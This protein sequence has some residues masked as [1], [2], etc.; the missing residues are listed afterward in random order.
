[1][2][3]DWLNA[4]EATEVGTALA[5]DVVVQTQSA[6][7]NARQRHSERQVAPENQ[8][9]AL[10]SR[11]LQAVDRKARPLQLNV[12]KR[13]KL[14]NSFKWRLLEKGVERQVVEELT[15]ALVLRLTAS[16]DVH[17]TPTSRARPTGGSHARH[18]EALL[19]RA[20]DL[21]TNGAYQDAIG[22]FEEFLE[23]KPRHAV[24]RNNLGVALIRLGHYQEAEEQFRRA[25]GIKED[26]PD[27][28]CNIGTLLRSTGR[29][30]E[31][32]MPL[33]RALK[34]RPAYLEAQISL[35]F[36]LLMLGRLSEAR[37]V[38]ELALKAAPRN[39]DALIAM[40]EVL[41]HE[42]RFG[43][44]ENTYRTVLTADPKAGGAWMGLVGLRKM[45]AADGDWLR[46][47]EASIVPGMAP[48][49][50][51]SLH[52][53]IGKYYD[54]LGR[55][56]R[57]FRSYQRANELWKMAAKP[58]LPKAREHLT[59]DLIRVY[60]PETLRQEHAGASDSTLPVFVVGMPRAGTT[61]VEQIIASHPGARGAG[62][63]E[64]WAYAARKHEAMQRQNPPD[65][66]TARKL[67]RDYLQ[68]LEKHRGDAT[69]VVDKSPF[70]TDYLGAIHSVF[71]RARVIYV[72]RNPIDVCL[73]CYFQSFAPSLNFTLDLTDL[74]HY[75]QE[76]ARLIAHWR[77]ALPAGTWFEVP[78]EALV[79]D[80]ER[81]TRSILEFLGLQW[82]ERCL[83][84]HQ[85]DRT[86]GTASVW[87]VRQKMYRTSVA[88]WRNYE[89]FIGPLRKLQDLA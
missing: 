49:N 8:L 10:L 32:E 53:A 85:T 1:M 11:F 64:Y 58:Y 7:R 61:L 89:K 2:L 59:D 5:D 82:H 4:R 35:G 84:F 79:T 66:G 71:P 73:S 36:T 18:A 70:N 37:T 15:K 43:D 87:Q 77:T 22:H 42:G 88:R 34:L 54:D 47:A 9:Q 38:L 20:N 16:Q 57:A 69:L 76:H 40:G 50:E 28:Q 21:V 46:G 26:Y 83:Q 44:A 86:V 29:L 14:A 19:V 80:Q 45:T 30:V 65:V 13:A 81:W 24:A 25:I 51:G 62:E 78:Y 31:A 72:R 48:V 17:A 74:A 27:A 75:Y 56:E 3:L 6:P 23:L 41:T 55:Y 67:A 60:S 12:F 52:F 33:R 39:P 68:I 63:L